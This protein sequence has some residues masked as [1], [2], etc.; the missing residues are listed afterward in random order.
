MP[1]PSNPP[2]SPQKPSYW[3]DF[4][5]QGIDVEVTAP[6]KDA[7]PGSPTE[8]PLYF[9]GIG[10]LHHPG[11]PTG[12]QPRQTSFPVYTGYSEARDLIGN[13]T[14]E[15]FRTLSNQAQDVI[16]E[17]FKGISD[18]TETTPSNKTTDLPSPNPKPVLIQLHL[19]PDLQNWKQ[20]QH[21]AGN[22]LPPKGTG[23][24]PAS[25]TVLKL[26]GATN[27]PSA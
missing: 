23:L 22:I 16:A 6:Q 17:L 15:E 20:A 1:L 7:F 5:L 14:V 25:D 8:I 4:S 13:G 26:F 10:F 11:K 19:S 12:W 9:W 2:L 3:A 18:V 21:Q 24:T 27:W